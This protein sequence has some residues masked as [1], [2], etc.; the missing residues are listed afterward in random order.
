MLTT[1]ICKYRIK[2]CLFKV[3]TRLNR[4]LV[5]IFPI[6][7]LSELAPHKTK[8]GSSEGK[9]DRDEQQRKSRVSSSTGAA[10][11]AKQP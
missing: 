4:D 6:A 10:Q 8:C 1:D 3:F 2:H 9:G 5:E 11:A 7:S